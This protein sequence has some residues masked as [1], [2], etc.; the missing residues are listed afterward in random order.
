[1]YVY[2]G[3]WLVGVYV[4]IEFRWEEAQVYIVYMA[5]SRSTLTQPIADA[6][7]IL[8]QPILLQQPAAAVCSHLIGWV[9]VNPDQPNQQL[10]AAAKHLDR[11]GQGQP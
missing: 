9:Q 7:S 10:P 2:S 5:G 4:F 11:L 8:T 3:C 1:M 6:G